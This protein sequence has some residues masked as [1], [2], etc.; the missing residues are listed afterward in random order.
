VNLSINVSFLISVDYAPVHSIL[1]LR[2]EV[3]N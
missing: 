1:L 2:T 3:P